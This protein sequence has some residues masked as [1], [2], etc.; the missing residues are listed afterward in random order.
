MPDE[1][2]TATARESPA[3][4][5]HTSISFLFERQ[6]L[7]FPLL[8]VFFAC[9]SFFFGGTCAAWQ[10][11]TAVA[12]VV[13][14]P[15]AK[16]KEWYAAL[17]AAGLFVLLL[18]F[19][20]CMIPSLVW[21]TTGC[22]DMSAY[23]LPMVQLLVE[24]W[25]PIVDPTAEKIVASLGIDLWGMAPLHVAFLP[26]TLAVFSAVAHTYV[27]D[28]YALAFPLLVFLWLGVFLAGM[29]I[30]RG[31]SRLALAA[32]LVFVLPDVVWKMPVDLSV[33]FAS[34]GLLLTMLE[35]LRQKECDWLSLV[36]WAAWMMN[37]KHNGVLG[38]FVFCALFVAAT[39]WKDR[40]EW[41]RWMIRF[42][43]FGGVLV[44]LWG[45]V[46]WNPLGTS[47]RNYGH[48]LYPFAT[49]D[50]K[51]F[52]VKDITWNLRLGNGDFDKMGKLGRLSFSCLSPEWTILYYR[53]KLHRPDFAPSCP[54]W[55]R[56]K[57]GLFSS[58]D[59][60]KIWMAF[61]ALLLLKDGRLW[62][63]CGLA[64][65]LIVP[66]RMTGYARYQPWMSS[67]E[68][69]AIALLSEWADSKLSERTRKGLSIALVVF[70]LSVFAFKMPAMARNLECKAIERSTIRSKIR[71]MFAV[72]DPRVYQRANGVVGFVPRADHAHYM[73]NRCRLL[74]KALRRE[75][76]TMVEPASDFL[77][78]SEN[79]RILLDERKWLNE[80]DEDPLDVFHQA[81]QESS[82]SLGLD[83]RGFAGRANEKWMLAPFGYWVPMD[84]HSL[85]LQSYLLMTPPLTGMEN[86]SFVLHS[87]CKTYP[88]EV[89]R[90]M[91][92]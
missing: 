49:V 4:M 63:V 52:P 12:A 26:K 53:R 24:G 81:G 46:S 39:I 21:D 67:L 85:H 5:D 74:V 89:Y 66:S 83:N 41:K 10:W 56:T 11:W 72:P 76:E 7:V 3:P 47:W 80:M 55:S 1:F 16:K 70:V 60:M 17:G 84:E 58:S 27:K 29:R 28:P 35:G 82:R 30:F 33:A 36:I 87:F 25:N 48:P 77:S 9:T 40:T 43:A 34:C 22:D 50:A 64:L 42:T 59:R 15:F 37:L 79:E 20:R 18:F 38:A 19:L 6:V 78:L 73:E 23:H 2:A 69:L 44:L 32:A 68:C 31:F 51:R 13:L 8:V 71:P 62:V 61:L 88:R 75:K 91:K 54:W 45:F 90:R 14:V 92:W 86:I 65:L 57:G